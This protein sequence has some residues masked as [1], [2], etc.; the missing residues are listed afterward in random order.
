[1]RIKKTSF[2]SHPEN[3]LSRHSDLTTSIDSIKGSSTLKNRKRINNQK[4][5]LKWQSAAQ[6]RI[7]IGKGITG[8]SRNN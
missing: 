5:V 8:N 1:D 2:L 3:G 6:K 4:F 7:L